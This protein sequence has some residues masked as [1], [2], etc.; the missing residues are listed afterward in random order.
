MGIDPDEKLIVAPDRAR[1]RVLKKQRI[2]AALFLLCLRCLAVL[3]GSIIWTRWS[4]AHQEP[5]VTEYLEMHRIERDGRT[6]I[7]MRFYFLIIAALLMAALG[8]R[9][10]HEHA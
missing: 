6:H 4:A 9:L 3:W 8:L 7:W 2:F 10:M 1:T 5:N